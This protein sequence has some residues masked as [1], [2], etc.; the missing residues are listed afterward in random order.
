[1]MYW[2]ISCSDCHCFYDKIVIASVTNSMTEDK[3]LSEKAGK[4]T[5]RH[6]NPALCLTFLLLERG[7]F[8]F[9]AARQPQLRS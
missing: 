8:H 4:L 3:P 2:F 9:S 6:R 1:M 5:T 7:P